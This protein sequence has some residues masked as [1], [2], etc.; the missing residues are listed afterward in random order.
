MAFK[1]KKKK[2]PQKMAKKCVSKK[3]KAKILLKKCVSK[4]EK[5]E[6]EGKKTRHVPLF[7]LFKI[8]FNQ[9]PLHI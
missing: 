9:Y 7:P 3:K 1:K 5:I 6:Q 8:P 2:S 4:K